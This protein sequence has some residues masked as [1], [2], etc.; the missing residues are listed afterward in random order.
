MHLL[1]SCLAAL[2][3]LAAIALLVL[4]IHTRSLMDGVVVVHE[5]GVE[6]T[7]VP[8]DEDK[9][10]Y[11]DDALDCL[12]GS[13]ACA[14]LAFLLALTLIEPFYQSRTERRIERLEERIRDL[15]HEAPPESLPRFDPP[16]IRTESREALI[17]RL[18]H[19]DSRG[20]IEAAREL[21][22]RGSDADAARDAL[23][24][25]LRQTN[26]ALDVVRAVTLTLLET[27]C[28]LG[29]IVDDLISRLDSSDPE[30]RGWAARMLG[31]IGRQAEHAVPA[32]AKRMGDPEIGDD[33][34]AALRAIGGPRARPILARYIATRER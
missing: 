10:T 9:L 18:L 15:T 24:R 1:R 4:G 27:S 7:V 5:D 32:L 29:V 20:K 17:R 2:L 28:D 34:I 31:R 19:E 11:A 8:S 13:A 33:V 25:T 14:L 22:K 21:R 30:M 12:M 16:P 23:I 6:E 3:L 26:G